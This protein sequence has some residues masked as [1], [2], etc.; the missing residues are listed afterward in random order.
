MGCPRLYRWEGGLIKEGAKGRIVAEGSTKAAKEA[1]R[2]SMGEKPSTEGIFLPVSQVF[3]GVD[4]TLHGQTTP[5]VS[6]L[7]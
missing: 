6:L 5:L 7:R 2:V 4:S 3:Q 1:E